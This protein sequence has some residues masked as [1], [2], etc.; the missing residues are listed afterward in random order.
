MNDE[1]ALLTKVGAK[2]HLRLIL[3]DKAHDKNSTNYFVNQLWM[4]Y[5]LRPRDVDK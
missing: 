5:Q 2:G 3:T 1:S 4:K